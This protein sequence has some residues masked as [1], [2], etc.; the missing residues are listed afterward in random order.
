MQP[1]R[2]IQLGMNVVEDE[3]CKSPDSVAWEVPFE[4]QQSSVDI[5][6]E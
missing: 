6:H 4:R 1:S 2:L 3:N 5:Y